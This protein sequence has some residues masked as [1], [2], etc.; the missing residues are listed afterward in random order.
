MSKVNPH[1]DLGTGY[2]RI[3]R[4]PFDQAIKIR[5]FVPQSSILS[6]NTS[7]GFVQDALEYSQYEYWFDF[8]HK[9]LEIDFG[10]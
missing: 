10:I 9:S 6:F 7:E 5:E 1:I 8:H 3:S 2:V 4:L